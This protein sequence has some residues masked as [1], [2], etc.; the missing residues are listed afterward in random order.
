MEKISAA[1]SM[2]VAAT[3]L[4]FGFTAVE[5]CT[6]DKDEDP[7][8]TADARV[9][10]LDL[11]S[12]I[13]SITGDYIIDVASAIHARME[14]AGRTQPTPVDCV[15]ALAS[16]NVP[17]TELHGFLRHIV[18]FESEHEPIIHRVQ[19]ESPLSEHEDD[20]TPKYTYTTTR[21][22][23]VP[24]YLPPFPDVHSYKRTPVYSQFVTDFVKLHIQKCHDRNEAQHSVAAMYCRVA[25]RS[26]APLQL[27]STEEELPRLISL[28]RHTMSYLASIKMPSDRPVRER[29]P[30]YAEPN[31]FLQLTTHNITDENN[32]DVI[33]DDAIDDDGDAPAPLATVEL[34][35][36]DEP[37][38][39]ME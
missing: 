5:T 19:E 7:S 8:D 25:N 36:D 14:L 20:V 21:P 11:L 3:L 33:N 34:A 23:H 12:L 39:G 10:S 17:L 13:G 32:D 4:D 9:A 2:S 27:T 24:A 18:Q 31:L 30:R 28:P 1:M 6:F 22:A 29:A 26:C 35:P 37:T 15:P 16:M 38:F